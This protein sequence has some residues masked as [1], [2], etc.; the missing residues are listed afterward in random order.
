MLVETSSSG[1]AMFLRRPMA[2]KRRLLMSFSGVHTPSPTSVTMSERRLHPQA[3][4]QDPELF[5]PAECLLKFDYEQVRLLVGLSP[6]Q[7]SSKGQ[8]GL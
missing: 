8:L 3:S 6:W 1:V 7:L 4:Q 5:H 2:V